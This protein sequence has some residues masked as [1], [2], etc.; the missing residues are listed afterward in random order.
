MGA[1]HRRALAQSRARLPQVWR[2]Y[3]PPAKL[4]EC[5]GDIVAH[6]LKVA[7]DLQLK[8]GFPERLVKELQETAMYAEQ[9]TRRDA[10]EVI[11]ELAALE[12]LTS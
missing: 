3:G 5:R 8:R 11:A 1:K 7:L 9:M 6:V 12:V 10:R 4:V 2:T